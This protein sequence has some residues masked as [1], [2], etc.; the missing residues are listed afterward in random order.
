MPVFGLT[1]GERVVVVA[2]HPDDETIG[3]GGTI[4]RMTAEGLQ[5]HVLCV[6]VRANGGVADPQE[7]VTEFEQACAALGVTTAAVVWIDQAGDMDITTRQRRLV[8]VITTHEQASLAAVRPTALMIPAEAG[9]HQDHCAVFRAGFA[10]ARPRPSV[11]T[12]RVVLGYRGVEEHWSPT[13]NAWPITVDTTD[14]WATKEQAL[15]CYRSQIRPDGQPRSLEH[16]RLVDAAV[17]AGYGLRYAEL[18]RPYRLAW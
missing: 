7:R 14:F 8:D 16:I 5:V 3:P 11:P 10:A 12:P 6:T 18:F 17:G 2:P 4:A 15:R 1:Q 9:Y 13:H